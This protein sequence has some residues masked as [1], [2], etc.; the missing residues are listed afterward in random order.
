M[1]VLLKELAKRF[2]S[3]KELRDGS[4]ECMQEILKHHRDY[5]AIRMDDNMRREHSVLDY[6]RD[7]YRADE[8]KMAQKEV[9]I[10]KSLIH[11]EKK[12]EPSEFERRARKHPAETV[13]MIY[14]CIS[15]QGLRIKRLR[16]MFKSLYDRA[17]LD[18]QNGRRSDLGLSLARLEKLS[19]GSVEKSPLGKEQKAN[20]L[21]KQHLDEKRNST[22]SKNDIAKRESTHVST[23]IRD[24]L[25]RLAMRGGRANITAVTA[26]IIRRTSEPAV[27]SSFRRRPASTVLSSPGADFSSTPSD[28][29]SFILPLS[30]VL[31]PR[32]H[33]PDR[34]KK[35]TLI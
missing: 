33:H 5:E 22:L 26:P 11:I 21:S 34:I 14:S 9:E 25:R 29:P 32:Q 10:E 3:E 8:E 15:L 23:E 16:T 35:I 12:L 31:T 1:N 30:N 24:V 19:L 17:E 2:A 28:P 7:E 27:S 13:H 6:L 20:G 4:R 18:N